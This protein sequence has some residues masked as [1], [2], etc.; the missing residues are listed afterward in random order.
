LRRAWGATK[1]VLLRPDVALGL[2]FACAL[3]LGGAWGTWQNLCAGDGCPSVAQ[4]RTFEHEQ[5]S[6]VLAHDGRQITEFGFERRTPVSI[7]A[8]PDY[9]SQAVISIEDKRFY[10][11]GGFDPRGIARAV[12]GVATLRSGA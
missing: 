1:R 7:H 10:D 12:Y 8:L 4:V 9:V 2:L 3:G 11:H 5:T 6:K